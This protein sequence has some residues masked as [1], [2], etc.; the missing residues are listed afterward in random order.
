RRAQAPGCEAATR[1]G[2]AGGGGTRAGGRR[3]GCE[4]ARG[5]LAHIPFELIPPFVPAKAGTQSNRS[6][7]R[8]VWTWVP[9]FAGTKGDRGSR[10]VD[11]LNVDRSIMNRTEQTDR[12]AKPA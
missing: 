6:K 8:C 12:R 1:R 2:Q 9:A 3:R 10:G 11:R 5:V 7:N 4:A